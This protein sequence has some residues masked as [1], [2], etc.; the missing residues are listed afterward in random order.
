[1]FLK[2]PSII[3]SFLNV[4]LEVTLKLCATMPLCFYQ[5][6]LNL[7][8]SKTE[9]SHTFIFQFTLALYRY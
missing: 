3:M 7:I 9:H 2:L 5:K 1:M 8:P 4:N 6:G